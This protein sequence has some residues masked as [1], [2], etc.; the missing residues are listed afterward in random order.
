ME[1][2]KAAGAGDLRIMVRHMLPNTIGLII[3]TAT[4]I[5]GVAIL[6]ES[7][8]WFLGFGI[9]PPTPTLGK[10]IADG[11]DSC[12]GMWWLV[13]FP[14]LTIVLILLCVDFVG[15]GLGTRSTPP[16]E[17]SVPEPILSIRDLTV[18]FTTEDGIVHAVEEVS[19]DVAPPRRSASWANRL[20]Q[21]REAMTVLGLIPLPPGKVTR[22][23][24][25]GPKPDQAQNK[26]LHQ[27]RGGEVAMIF[28]D[29]MT[30]LNPVLTVGD[31]IGEAIEAHHP[32]SQRGH[33]RTIE[34]LAWSASRTGC[35]R[36]ASTR[37]SSRAGCASGR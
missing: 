1:A 36:T 13:T 26:E 17:G 21:E 4:L 20:G 23:S 27:V 6:T 30:S 8:L 2:A 14:G 24:V 11:Q 31:Q 12:T 37:T 22:R 9:Q 33:E 10:L 34:L 28:Q 5:I 7:V 18:E 32:R 15:D 25:Q 29:P 3:V 35:T 19:Y 16:N